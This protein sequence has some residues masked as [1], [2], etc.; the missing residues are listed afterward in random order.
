[1][2]VVCVSDPVF[3]QASSSQQ[4]FSPCCSWARFTR[5][6]MRSSI[7]ATTVSR[8]TTGWTGSRPDRSSELQ[9]REDT[10][11]ASGAAADAAAEATGG[12][13][14]QSGR[15]APPVREPAEA[16]DADRNSPPDKKAAGVTAIDPAIS[17]GASTAAGSPPPPDASAAP[18]GNVESMA[19]ATNASKADPRIGSGALDIDSP[20]DTIGSSL[21]PL[22]LTQPVIHADPPTGTAPIEGAKAPGSSRKQHPGRRGARLKAPAEPVNRA[23]TTHAAEPGG[24]RKAVR[25]FRQ[26]RWD[27][28]PRYPVSGSRGAG[29]GAWSGG[30]P[31][32]NGRG[33]VEEL[34]F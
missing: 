25:T 31:L 30:Y 6:N 34:R 29:H 12:I 23:L 5:A 20:G 32:A 24:A 8:S 27:P 1:M 11:G 7:I 2:Q 22:S 33:W 15:I 4:H 18:P 10:H 19:P 21:P 14:R 13:P 17:V 16:D 3:P 28:P 9:A 26:R